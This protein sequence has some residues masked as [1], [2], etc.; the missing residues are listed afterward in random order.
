MVQSHTDPFGTAELRRR[1]LHSWA[2]APAR[3]REDAN[4]EEDYALG[5]YRDRAVVELAQNAA[6]AARRA[7]VPG[8]LRL[9]LRGGRLSAANTGAPLT[10]AGVQSLSTLRASAKRDEGEPGSTGRFG[11]GFSAVAAFSDDITIASAPGAVRW[12][13]DLARAALDAEVADGRAPGLGDELQ[14]RGGH[15]P[16]LRLPFAAQAAPAGGYDTEVVLVL[17]D[18]EAADRLRALLDAATPA[19]L[20]ALGDLAEI[21]IAT[22]AGERILT[23]EAGPGEDV[24]TRVA[25]LG[26]PETGSDGPQPKPAAAEPHTVRWRTVTRAGRFDPADLADRPS[27]ERSRLDWALTWAVP[28]TSEGAAAALPE[29]VAGVVHAPTPTDDVLDVP[30]LLIGT[31]PLGPDRRRVAAGRA[32]EALVAE[33]ADAYC[34]LLRKLDPRAALELVPLSLMGRGEFDGRFRSA[35]AKPLLDTPFLRTAGGEPVRPRD[36]VVLDGGPEVVAALSDVIG[37][38]LPGDWNPYHPALAQLRVRRVGLSELADLLGDLDRDPAWWAGLYAALRAAGQRGAD[39]GELGALPVPLADGRLV[40]GPRGLLLPAADAFGGAVA[41]AALAPLGLR[42]VHPEAADPLLERLGAVEAGAAAILADPQTRAAVENSLD[43]DDPDTVS[44]PVLDLVALAETTAD[45]APWLAELALRDDEGGYS[46]AGELLLP[47]SPLRDILVADAPFGVVA[48]DLVERYGGAALAAVGVLDSFAVARAADLTLGAALED[49]RSGTRLE[50]LDGLDEWAEEVAERLGSPDLPPVVAEF[51]GVADLE[52]VREDRW[53]QA[54]ELLSGPRLRATVTEP[55]RVLGERGEVADVPSYTAWWLRTGAVLDGRNPTDLRAADADPVLIGLYDPA[56]EALDADLAAALGVRSSLASLLAESDG[57]DDLLERIAD[58]ARHVER[59]ALRELWTALA[60][61]DPDRVTPPERL[62]AVRGGSIVLADAED[63]VVV[64]RPDLLPLLHGRPTVPVPA[65]SA[66]ALADVLDLAL[67][68]E[69]VEGEVTSTG[70]VRPVP[71]EAAAFLPGGT[72]TYVH[73]E[74]L[75]V[76]GTVV[77]WHC[78]GKT[79]HAATP[80]GLA[81]ALCWLA[82]R[83]SSRH[84]VAAVLRDPQTLPALLAEADLDD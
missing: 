13:R 67:A 51:A 25:R 38:A 82:D 26:P 81:R 41:A 43:A 27:E 76:D 77:E 72:L 4:A 69:E 30:A 73:H 49:A 21:R 48:Q 34:D 44:G 6:D 7:G 3:F 1:V 32:A 9:E 33:A 56:P 75:T 84:L 5:A 64:D 80:D 83:W 63:A 70:E 23:R 29:G 28:I 53:P 71:D 17:R 62:R 35:A 19:L 16:L 24:L 68:G 15:L 2:D 39:L 52:F 61:V 57:P 46:V 37:T 31:F 20:L 74:E 11:V 12:S 10:P 66:A 79:A 58:P 78:D 50:G 18:A 22:D 8:T 65:R 60:G 40:R 45:D 36:A 54:L 59:R 55:A 42:I 14:R 47:S